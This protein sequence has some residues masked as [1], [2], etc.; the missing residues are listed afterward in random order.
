MD[1]VVFVSVNLLLTTEEPRE[2]K[3]DGDPLVE[4]LSSAITAEDGHPA[5]LTLGDL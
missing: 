4:L 2:G 3:F 1:V 5:P